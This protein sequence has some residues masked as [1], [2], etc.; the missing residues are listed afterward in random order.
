MKRLKT[1][2]KKAEDEKT[3]AKKHEAV[4]TAPCFFCPYSC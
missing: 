2:N 1:K 4:M 3:A